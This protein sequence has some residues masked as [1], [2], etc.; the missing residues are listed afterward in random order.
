MQAGEEA[1]GPN[2][3]I[4]QNSQDQIFYAVTPIDFSLKPSITTAD[5][6]RSH[7]RKGSADVLTGNSNQQRIVSVGLPQASKTLQFAS[8]KVR[9]AKYN[10]ITW[11]PKSL[12]T[13]FYRAANVYFLI[14]SVLSAQYFSPKTPVSIIGTFVAVLFFTMLKE[15][16]ED[17]GRHKSDHKVNSAQTQRLDRASNTFK[18]VQTQH[19]RVG[20]IVKIEDDETFPADIL[21][22]ACEDRTGLAFVN[23]MNLDGET[24]LKERLAVERTKTVKD[25]EG[26]LAL[27]L[28]VHCDAPNA[29]LVRWNCNVKVEGE[30]VPVSLSQL[31][32]RGCTLKNSGYAYGAVIYTGH[33]T[34]S[35]LNSKEAP[36]KM[37]HVLRLMNRMLYTVFLVQISLCLLFAG[38]SVNWND[39]YAD[40]HDYLAISKSPN[41]QLYFIQVLTFLVA[42]S[43]L[44]PI[45]LYVALE[46]VKL[47]LAYLISQDKEMFYE[48]DC[49]PASCR[50]SDLVEELGQVSFVFSDKTG[51][52][53][54][55]VMEFKKCC[56][57]DQ[58]FGGGERGDSVKGVAGDPTPYQIVENRSSSDPLRRDIEQFFLS[59]ALCHS[60][61]PAEIADQPGCYKYQST[62]PDELALVQGSA[63]MGVLLCGKEDNRL[64]LKL[65]SG[66]VQTWEIL[67]EIAFS[68]DRR[69]MSV[70]VREVGSSK[71]RLLTKG[72][73]S[74]MF[75]LLDSKQ[76]LTQMELNIND[77]AREGLRTLVVCQ[78]ELGQREFEEWFEVWHSL[79]LSSTPD[80]AE[81]Q[82]AHGARLEVDLT[83]LG[84]TAIE[85]KLQEGVPEAI[86][87]LMDAG[88]R[89]WVLTGDKQETAIQIAKSC[90]LIRPACEL[91]DLSSTNYDGFKAKLD[92]QSNRF[93]LKEDRKAVSA[94]KANLQNMGRQV[95]VVIDGATLVWALNGDEHRTVFFNLG[96]VSNSFICCRVSPAQKMEVVKL[97]KE[98]GPWITLAIGDGANDV[99]MIQEA[100]IGVGIAGKE[101][102]QAVQSSDYAFSQFR[103]LTR[104]LLVHGR[105]NYRRVSWFICYYFYKNIAVVFAELWFALFNG[106]SGQ[107][108]FADWLPQLYN[109]FWTSWPCMFTFVFEQDLDA[110]VSLQY[111]VVYAAGQRNL[112]F[113]YRRFWLWIL[114]GAY[115]GALCFWI[116][117]A[118]LSDPVD[119]TGLNNGLWWTST[120][121]FTLII[122]VVTVKLY[123]ESG[124]WT[125]ISIAAGICS[126]LFYYS[127]VIVLNAPK[128]ASVF[129]P[130]L[131][132]VF[133]ELLG[134]GK[135]W[136][137]LV[138]TPIVA[139]LPDFGLLLWQSLLRP[140]PIEKLRRKSRPLSQDEKELPLR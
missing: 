9:T 103:Y 81:R 89:V 134:T 29:S 131:I 2:V 105:W 94:E 76:D 67:A 63:D 139:L 127:T 75:P 93:R 40:K 11:A 123:L 120:L 4:E 65:R 106:F 35:M 28:E 52:L 20:D 47:A 138:F 117:F 77:F 33:E 110:A 66:L 22:L 72:A 113:N 43:H 73:D 121:T 19:I 38:L 86:E 41:G 56:I 1:A 90:K 49:R 84:V 132:Y 91:I 140:T 87:S 3:T 112:Y 50:T 6:E 102:S 100:H 111:P 70:V 37:S 14:I 5:V 18:R 92:Q 116:P 54:R 135:T 118:G 60:V 98:Q 107:I 45:S 21:L 61:F 48:E 8:N 10:L 55:N 24:N 15:A 114:L 129:Q 12:L 122:H 137:A 39:N 82:A 79:L 68:S 7:S 97:A 27:E 133:F 96:F 69:R 128:I 83:L 62:S 25:A 136:I 58:V 78:R 108:Y 95:A 124:Y 36:S 74:V 31:L 126:I 99:S 57:A 30:L 13:Q 17:W 26:L 85:D 16:Y 53:T 119:S 32:L 46:V 71:V 125:K 44:I 115:H 109:S 59:L 51:T 42:Y 88:I 101:G 130:Q 34:K 80:K 64:K 23:T 104:L